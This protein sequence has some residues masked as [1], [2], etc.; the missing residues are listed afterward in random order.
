MALI[1]FYTG[2]PTD[3]HRTVL[4]KVYVPPFPF[5]AMV[6]HSA[7]FFTTSTTWMYTFLY[8]TYVNLQFFFFLFE[9]NMIY[10]PTCPYVQGSSKYLIFCHPKYPLSRFYYKV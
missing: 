3:E 4:E 7:A 5:L 2:G 6:I 10:F 8:C 1:A 9:F